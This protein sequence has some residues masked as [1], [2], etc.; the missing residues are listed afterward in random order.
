MFIHNRQSQSWEKSIPL[1]ILIKN[2]ILGYAKDV[3]DLAKAVGTPLF[4]HTWMTSLAHLNINR[5][6]FGDSAVH[7]F[8][9]SLDLSNTVLILLSDH[10]QR[11]GAIR[12]TLPGWYEDKLPILSV[13]LP[14]NVRDKAPEWRSNLK[15]NAARLTSPFDLYKM[16]DSILKEFSNQTDSLE[17]SRTFGESL[18]GGPISSSR[19]CED[20]G[21]GVNYCACVPPRKI[22]ASDP[23]LI[24][25]AEAAVKY[26][27]NNVPLSVC[28]GAR[29]DRVVAGALMANDKGDDKPTY[30]VSFYTEPGQFLFEATVELVNSSFK[31]T[32]DLLRMN[33]IV[34]SASC[35][36]TSLLERYCYCK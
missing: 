5:A 27:N 8:I 17:N 16:M 6:A 32:T 22:D 7:S 34:R 19:R 2:G 29:L 15:E 25:A 26:L 24:L 1:S 23:T 3:V 4:L 36:K 14:P 9:S 12:E 30:V 20:A 21:V 10:G 18:V 35:V 33:K 13:Y 31:I 11:Y 28:E